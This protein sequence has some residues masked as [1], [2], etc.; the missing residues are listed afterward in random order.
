MI[1]DIV[2]IDRMIW[3]AS[4]E[5]GDNEDME[6]AQVVE[7]LEVLEQQLEF[8]KGGTNGKDQERPAASRR[9]TRPLPRES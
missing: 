9:C 1:G 8:D 4:P 2:N 5:P 6:M 3:D 7:K